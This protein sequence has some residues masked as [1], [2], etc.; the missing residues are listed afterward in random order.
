VSC[1]SS[2]AG[3]STFSVVVGVGDVVIVAVVVV[4]VDVVGGGA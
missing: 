1:R 3:R 2:W 4:V